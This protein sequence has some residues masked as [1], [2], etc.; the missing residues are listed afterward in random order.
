[1]VSGVVLCHILPV[2]SHS[3][4]ENFQSLVKARYMSLST[5][6]SLDPAF[7]SNRSVL[8]SYIGSALT[9]ADIAAIE[10]ISPHVHA[11]VHSSATWLHL[12]T[13]YFPMFNFGHEL[14]LAPIFEIKAMLCTIKDVSVADEQVIDLPNRAIATSFVNAAQ[15]A[16]ASARENEKYKAQVLAHTFVWCDPY[17]G[18]DMITGVELEDGVEELDIDLSDDGVELEDGV[19]VLDIDLSDDVL[20]NFH[21]KDLAMQFGWSERD[22]SLIID[23]ECSEFEY[24]QF[25]EPLEKKFDVDVFAVGDCGIS[26]RGVRTVIDGHLG[27]CVLDASADPRVVKGGLLTLC[28]IREA[29]LS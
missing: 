23:L 1:M 22:S 20:F 18:S 26:A 17:T 6:L 24:D 5:I 11:A 19:E 2:Q 16:L 12:A 25:G 21:G 10:A 28:C 7:L 29:P 9:F 14:F 4:P 3:L 27:V 15:K 8:I 13:G